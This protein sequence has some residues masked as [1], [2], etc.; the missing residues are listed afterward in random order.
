VA[1]SSLVVGS[2]S[3]AWRISSWNEGEGMR[4]GPW[5]AHAERALQGDRATIA[6]VAVYA[7]FALRQS[8]VI[9]FIAHTDDAGQ[10][11]RGSCTYFVEGVDI[12]ARYWS[13]TAYDDDAFLMPNAS[14]RFGWNKFNVPRAS[15]GFRIRVGPEAS[16]ANDDGAAGNDAE[17][18][19]ESIR[20]VGAIP[21][22]WLPTVPNRGVVL[23]LR[24]YHPGPG[25]LDAPSSFPAPRI[26][27]EGPC[28]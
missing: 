2:A 5:F 9:Y 3:A 12:D 7:L 26:H 28:D 24:L 15:E 20:N 22:A 19:S 1:L 25:V 13:V 4:N 27:A 10:P 16:P 23:V 6:Q 11:L 8:E 21:T 14:N 18:N 17:R